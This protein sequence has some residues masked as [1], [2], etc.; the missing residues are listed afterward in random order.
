MDDPNIL[1]ARIPTLPRYRLQH[2]DYSIFTMP[3]GSMFGES[4][5]FKHRNIISKMLN[6]VNFNMDDILSKAKTVKFAN[7]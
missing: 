1:L 3:D 7:N 2:F 4:G 6:D 5:L